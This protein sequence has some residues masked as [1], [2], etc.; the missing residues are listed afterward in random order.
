MSSPSVSPKTQGRHHASSSEE[1]DAASAREWLAKSETRESSVSVQRPVSRPGS[2][3]VTQKDVSRYLTRRGQ[4][5]AFLAFHRNGRGPETKY[6]PV[7]ANGDVEFDIQIAVGS[8]VAYD[9]DQLDE[10]LFVVYGVQLHHMYVSLCIRALEDL[11]LFLLHPLSHGRP[12]LRVT[13]GYLIERDI[14]M[15]LWL[16][17]VLWKAL[18]A[19]VVT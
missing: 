5:L 15:N 12:V 3:G 6:P 16:F 17:L 7:S 8:H 19:A 14:I 2:G 18:P 13:T 1:A 10:V 11:A 9:Q 4:I